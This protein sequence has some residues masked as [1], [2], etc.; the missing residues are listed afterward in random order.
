MNW[1]G[2]CFCQYPAVPSPRRLDA[3]AGF[4][5]LEMLVV[6]TIMS[7]V[8]MLAGTARWQS[9][10][11]AELRG[12][13]QEFASSLRRTRS[14]AVTTGIV[15]GLRV[16]TESRQYVGVHTNVVGSFPKGADVTMRELPASG[17]RRDG[18]VDMIF[19]PDGTSLCGAMTLSRNGVRQ[20][21]SIDRLTGHVQISP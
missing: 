17:R 5:L 7:L 11:S 14:Q 6:M 4:T 20:D 12:S 13:L 15:V 1:R 2:S 21:V 18:T 9:T 16:D 10:E 3:A 19:L 8:L